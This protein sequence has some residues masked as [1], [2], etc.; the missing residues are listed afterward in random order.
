MPARL[1]RAAAKQPWQCP[2]CTA[3]VYSRR[4]FA[5][6]ASQRLIGPES[7]RYI[8]IPEPP[9]QTTPDKRREKGLLPVPRD[10]FSGSAPGKGLDKADPENIAL[11]TKEPSKQRNAFASPDASRLAWKE[12]MAESRR[13]NLREG[14]IALKERR[15]RTD[16]QLARR[17]RQRQE[18]REALLHRPERED[19]RL[20]NPSVD[21]NLRALL[22]KGALQN[23]DKETR[24]A[25][26]RARTQ[27][28]Q[29]ERREERTDALH[30]LYIEARDFIT[31]EA[32]LN[33]AI[34][35]EFGTPENPL[36]I[37]KFNGDLSMWSLGRP[38][39]V[40][41][42]LNQAQRQGGVGAVAS[43]ANTQPTSLT[44]ERVQRM[45]EALTGGRMDNASSR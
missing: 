8:E 21:A 16:T 19:E 35:K 34:D 28:R 30:S 10:I 12:R 11:S 42:M 15:I 1:A 38:V 29:Q 20:T 45:A 32:Q 39:N 2:S 14:L 23:P 6:T 41:G 17:G 3:S 33:S 44:K 5:A 24:L 4:N 43:K 40:Q 18:E 22:V 36:P 27:R 13:K 31:T 25:E 37:D 7:P 9:Q 26:M